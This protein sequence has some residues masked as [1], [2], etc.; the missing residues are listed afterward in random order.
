MVGE[1]HD[2]GR[3]AGLGNHGCTTTGCEKEVGHDD[4]ELGVPK[5]I[6]GKTRLSVVG[7]L[8]S[9]FGAV[10]RRRWKKSKW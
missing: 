6:A 10:L 2:R 3:R 5:E 9:T 7:R 4:D 8:E 1:L